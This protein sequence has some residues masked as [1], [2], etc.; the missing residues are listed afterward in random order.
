MGAG[1]GTLKPVIS[2]AVIK[3]VSENISYCTGFSPNAVGIGLEENGV[4]KCGVV[5]DNYSGED[6]HMSIAAE[7]PKWCSRGNLR[8][9]FDYPFNQLNCARVT[10]M[11]AKGNKRTRRMCEGLGFT[12]EGTHKKA[13]SGGQT[14]ISYGLIKEDCKWI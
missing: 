8:M 9:F 3:W 5:Y 10:A 6:I 13:F 12:H 4:L 1:D 2:Q 7:T 14:A 11:T